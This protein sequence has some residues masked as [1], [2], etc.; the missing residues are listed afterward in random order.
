MKLVMKKWICLLI[1][2]L[3]A[4]SCSRD[5]KTIKVTSD[6]LG[7]P[8]EVNGGYVGVTPC[9]IEVLVANGNNFARP[10]TI[11]ALPNEPGQYSQKKMF[12]GGFNS[13]VYNDAVPGRVFFQ[14][15]LRTTP[16]P[17]LDIN[18]W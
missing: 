4:I 11:T 13:P 1:V 15:A 8:I 5:V 9:D 2:S 17:E 6:P 14:M 7:V 16:N 18:L 10:T 12:F 3:T